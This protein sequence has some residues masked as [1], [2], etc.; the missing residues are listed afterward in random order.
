[1]KIL[2]KATASNDKTR[3]LAI[4]DWAT[5]WGRWINAMNWPVPTMNWYTYHDMRIMGVPFLDRLKNMW[6]WMFK[7]ED[8]EE[9][10]IE[11]YTVDEFF[12]VVKWSYNETN[13]QLAEKL[14]QDIYDKVTNAVELGQRKLIKRLLSS[15][16]VVKKEI[17]MLN[18]LGYNKYVRISDVEKIEEEKAIKDKVIK[19]TTM[20]EYEKEIPEENSLEIAKAIESGAFDDIM[21]MYTRPKSQV[22]KEEEEARKEHNR[23]Y[24]PIA[25]GCIN[26]SDK[27]YFITD[28]IDDECDFTLAWLEKIISINT[29]VS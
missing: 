12:S 22:K 24:D 25:F 9:E 18:K 2:R 19:L 11:Y 10:E 7:K 5:E 13:I 23:K 1:M 14:K 27:L 21:I 6:Y 3:L 26:D 8:V 16:E 4:S 29:L 20:G 28:W 17:A 15:F